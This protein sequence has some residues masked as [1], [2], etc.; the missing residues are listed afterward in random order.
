MEGTIDW[1]KGLSEIFTKERMR[2]VETIRDKKPESIGKLSKILSR[3]IA[4]VHRDL[5]V[6]E[7]YEI[8]RLEKSGRVVKPILDKTDLFIQI[9]PE[10]EE[11]LETA[12]NPQENGE[13]PD[14]AM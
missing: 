3:D 2:I 6:L 12:E 5:K 11:K 4:A 8:I 9:A 1:N 13:N 10:V 7:K 14:Y